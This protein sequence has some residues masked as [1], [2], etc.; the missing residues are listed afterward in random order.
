MDFVKMKEELLRLSN[1][2]CII[3]HEVIIENISFSLFS[4]DFLCVLGAN[5]VG[6]SVL[7]KIICGYREETEGK[8][9]LSGK[10]STGNIRRR[11]IGFLPENCAM[12]D[13]LTV[14]EN[15]MVGKNSKPLSFFNKYKLESTV[16][17]YLGKYNLQIKAGQ[18]MRT[19]TNV[20]RK[21]VTLIR[22]LINP[23]K[24]LVVD[25]ALDYCSFSEIRQMQQ[26]LKDIYQQG[27]AI[28]YLSYEYRWPKEMANRTIVIKDGMIVYHHKGKCDDELLKKMFPVISVEETRTMDLF[29]DQSSDRILEMK[30][31]GAEGVPKTDFYLGRNEIVGIIGL[32]NSNVSSFLNCLVGLNPIKEG[33]IYLNGVKTNINSQ[34]KAVKSGIRICSDDVEESRWKYEEI[35]KEVLLLGVS[36]RYIFL[37]K[38][39]ENLLIQE[40]FD[41]LKMDIDVNKPINTLNYANYIKVSIASC[42]ID[43]PYVLILNKLTRGLDKN[44]MQE[45]YMSL[46]RIKQK[47]SIIVNLSKSENELFFCDRIIVWGKE[48]IVDIISSDDKD[49]FDRRIKKWIR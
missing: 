33:K 15:L 13:T 21:L 35:I 42:L 46:D 45:L 8:I 28:I 18:M 11:E 32:R 26:I 14:A 23:P 5:G 7:A 49:E 44:G 1:I 24:I 20:K 31:I 27:T 12:F 4:G 47:C 34:T 48:G 22:Y 43:Q 29:E 17:E 38:K 40:C 36:Q 25:C 3:N 37:K 19:L 10:L 6:K 9:Y 39:Y 2:K 41:L 16:Q 30:G